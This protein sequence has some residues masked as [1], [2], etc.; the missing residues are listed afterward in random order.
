MTSGIDIHH[1]K[2]FDVN[3]FLNENHDLK[4]LY[5]IE[6]RDT[7]KEPWGGWKYYNAIIVDISRKDFLYYL[8]NKT[9]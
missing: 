2:D 3:Q 6:W 8:K 4:T 1:I 5:V 7:L 9:M